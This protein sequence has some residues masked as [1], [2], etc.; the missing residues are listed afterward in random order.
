MAKK[1]AKQGSPADAKAAAA[2]KAQQQRDE[3]L[4]KDQQADLDR[5]RRQAAI[6]ANDWW[7]RQS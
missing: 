7:G 6:D 1:A 2:K 5:V 3:Q 4:L